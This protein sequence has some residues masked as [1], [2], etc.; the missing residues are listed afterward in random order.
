MSHQVL[1]AQIIVQAIEPRIDLQQ[2]HPL[3]MLFVGTTAAEKLPVIARHG[4]KR[5]AMAV[6]IS[7]VP[8][9]M[10]KTDKNPGALP[11]SVFDDL[12]AQLANN[13]L[14]STRTLRFRSTDTTGP[15][16]RFRKALGNTFGCRA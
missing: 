6:L 5:V 7:A 12:Q 1:E 10:G 3:A 15:A 2:R 9:L 14:S 8:P 4:T 13:R 16:P 11:V